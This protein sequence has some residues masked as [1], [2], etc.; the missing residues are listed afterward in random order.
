MTGQTIQPDDLK[1]RQFVI[2]R[3]WRANEEAEE[4]ESR[5]VIS[6][7]G[8]PMGYEP[9]EKRPTCR[10]LLVL[11][12]LL[13]YVVVL[14]V[15]SGDRYPLDIRHVELML[16]TPE[17]VAALHPKLFGLPAKTKM[18]PSPFGVHFA[19]G[20]IV[21]MTREMIKDAGLDIERHGDDEDDK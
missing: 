4:F 16:V 8:L 2:V 9:R 10:P 14:D 1:L 3:A 21:K 6:V 13:P 11:A 15:A 18:G 17:F 7:F 12:I 19:D 20:G 5:R